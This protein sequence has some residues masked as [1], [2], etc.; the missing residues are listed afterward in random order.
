MV[1]TIAMDPGAGDASNPPQAAVKAKW[2]WRCF[3]E[4]QSNESYLQTA[5]F[6]LARNV[7]ITAPSL[8]LQGSNQDKCHVSN[9]LRPKAMGNKS[10]STGRWWVSGWSCLLHSCKPGKRL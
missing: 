10:C 5:W 8:P 2:H 3:K 4:N 6:C 7:S 1:I 9:F